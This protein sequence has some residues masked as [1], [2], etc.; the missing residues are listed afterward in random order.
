MVTYSVGLIETICSKC[1]KTQSTKSDQV[2]TFRIG[3]VIIKTHAS[4]EDAL[5]P[6]NGEL[7]V[8]KLERSGIKAIPCTGF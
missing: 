3:Q 8:I 5:V 6:C 2:N 4:N 7:L 1:N